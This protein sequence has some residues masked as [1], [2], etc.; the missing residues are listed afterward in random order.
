MASINQKYKNAS[1]SRNIFEKLF[2][3][4]PKAND[5]DP[6]KRHSIDELKVSVARDLEAL[7]NTRRS[8]FK[9]IKQFPLV[10]ESILGFG[11]LDFVGLSTANPM[12]CDYI[13]KEIAKTVESHDHRLKYVN[14]TLDLQHDLVN[15][16]SFSID[17]LM[18]VYPAKEYVSF[19]A[20]LQPSTQ[21]YQVSCNVK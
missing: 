7:F 4:N 18:V 5:N 9:T 3:D 16:L 6:L 2:D 19:D 17:A 8:K 14:V 21:R 15:A 20:L 10:D 12:D 1:F 13:C 11:I